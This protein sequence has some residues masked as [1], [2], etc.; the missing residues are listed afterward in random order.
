[1][2][3]PKAKQLPPD[4]E[5]M[6]DNRAKWA[7]DALTTFRKATKTDPED[8]LADLLCDLMHWADRNGNDFSTELERARAHYAEETLADDDPYPPK[9]VR[10][11]SVNFDYDLTFVPFLPYAANPTASRERF[12]VELTRL[13][14]REWEAT[15][16]QVLVKC[17]VS[18]PERRAD[19]YTHI[20]LQDGTSFR[21]DI[22]ADDTL[23]KLEAVVA[24]R[25]VDEIKRN[26]LRDLSWV[27]WPDN[28]ED[29]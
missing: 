4:P 3:R 17:D 25:T 29:E 8:Q 22:A 14:A 15:N 10:T 19:E 23:S 27:V 28:P 20:V 6:N 5:G 21:S 7:A 26:L 12:I 2:P 9:A 11:V 1:M 24:S 18:I 16:A 13:L